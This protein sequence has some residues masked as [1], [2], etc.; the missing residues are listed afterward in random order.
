MLESLEWVHLFRSFFFFF[1]STPLHSL[2]TDHYA[3]GLSTL[4]TLK[5]FEE[6]R[7]I[8][9]KSGRGK[10]TQF[11]FKLLDLLV[12]IQVCVSAKRIL[13]CL[14]ALILHIQTSTELLSC[15]S[16]HTFP[17]LQ[18]SSQS[19]PSPPSIQSHPSLSFFSLS[20]LLSLLFPCCPAV[21]SWQGRHHLVYMV[22]RAMWDCGN[23]SICSGLLCSKDS[24]KK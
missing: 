3:L 14:Y 6:E 7:G 19:S 24:I 18:T 17:S 10:K 15:S 13:M 22:W 4:L 9:R 12:Y 16:I 1:L 20:Q 8:V 23:A 11:R 5:K 2:E 21:C